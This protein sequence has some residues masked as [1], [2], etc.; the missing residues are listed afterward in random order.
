[1]HGIFQDVPLTL[2]ARIG[3]VVNFLGGRPAKLIGDLTT[4][5]NGG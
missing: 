2:V 1:M 5:L 4:G 3:E